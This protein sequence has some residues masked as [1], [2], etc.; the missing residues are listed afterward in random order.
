MGKR[1]TLLGGRTAARKARK[2]T[3]EVEVGRWTGKERPSQSRAGG[4]E[5]WAEGPAGLETGHPGALSCTSLQDEPLCPEVGRNIPKADGAPGD[6]A[7]DPIAA[8]ILQS[9]RIGDSPRFSNASPITPQASRAGLHP[10]F[11][12]RPFEMGEPRFAA[13][14]TPSLC[15]HLPRSTGQDVWMQRLRE[16]LM[17]QIMIDILS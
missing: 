5:G 9:R 13:T 11:P 1:L 6:I 10:S 4:G 15:T 7:A 2:R 17:G 8:P 12:P 3:S 16:W 14:S